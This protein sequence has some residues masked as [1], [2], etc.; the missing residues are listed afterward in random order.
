MNCKSKDSNPSTNGYTHGTLTTKL[1]P[2]SCRVSE[3]FNICLEPTLKRG[4]QAQ[5]WERQCSADR[6][7]ETTL[8]R[9]DDAQASL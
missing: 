2:L 7:V 6:A 1:Q 4:G 9:G 3:E 5:A 8:K